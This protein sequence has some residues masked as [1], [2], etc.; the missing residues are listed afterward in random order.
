MKMIHFEILNEAVLGV[1]FIDDFPS[2]GLQN[3]SITVLH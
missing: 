1:K 3:N 2:I